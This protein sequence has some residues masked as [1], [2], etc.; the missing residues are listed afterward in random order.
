M[1]LIARSSRSGLFLSFSLLVVL[2]VQSIW[3]ST[4][5]CRFLLSGRSVP[6]ALLAG[7]TRP[8][9]LL[10]CCSYASSRLKPASIGFTL[11]EEGPRGLRPRYR[12][13]AASAALSLEEP[14]VAPVPAAP[15]LL[16]L[17][18]CCCCC[19]CRARSAW[20]LRNR[21]S[22]VSGATS[23]GAATAPADLPVFAS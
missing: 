4:G 3:F 15:L 23:R 11:S 8:C 16:T 20:R 12:A 17:L 13:E 9:W 21:S 6:L 18:L 22:A 14:L 5:C 2:S 19:C 10:P 7:S 1:S